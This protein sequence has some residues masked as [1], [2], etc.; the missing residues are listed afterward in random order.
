MIN[1]NIIK[2]IIATANKEAKDIVINEL[3]NHISL[4]YDYHDSKA[5]HILEMLVDPKTVVTAKDVNLDYINKNLDILMYKSDKCDIRN[6]KIDN[7]DNIEC[8][9]RV[10]YEYLE[11]VNEDRDDAS[12]TSSYTDIN[13]ID[14]PDILKETVLK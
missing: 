7:V 14:N 9:I 11:K 6:I 2:A 5:N 8:T 3:L 13:F 12:Y 10:T 1:K 4:N